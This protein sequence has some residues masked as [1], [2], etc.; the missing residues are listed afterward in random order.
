M[1]DPQLSPT[2]PAT[3]H[4]ACALARVAVAAARV[5]TLVTYARHP[6]G[7]LSTAVEVAARADGSVEVRLAARS[8]A[9]RQLLARPLATV[10][11]APVGCPPVLLHGAARRLPGATDD[12][13]VVFH[14]EAAAVRVGEHCRPVDTRDYAAHRPGA[15]VVLR[16]QAAQVLE[17]LNASH[18]D[19][20]AA[21]VRDAGHRGDYVLAT[22][23]DAGGLTVQVV[24]RSGVET[25]RLP[26]VVALTRPEHLPAALSALL[27][28]R[29]DCGHDGAGESTG[30]R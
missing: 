21:H 26:F 27:S 19:L 12:G 8:H 29:C 16:H 9:V 20:L 2:S 15:D 14:V 23:V 30:P 13:R 18:A 4:E 28:R 1:L 22:R 11:I 3:A 5:G 24:G 10:S 7:Q 25:V 17:H 6:S